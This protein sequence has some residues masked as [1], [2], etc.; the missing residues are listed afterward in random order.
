MDKIDV[1]KR[2]LIYTELK[3]CISCNKCIRECPILKSNVVVKDAGGNYKICVDEKNCILCGT[4][5]YTCVHDVRHYMDDCGDFLQGLKNGK[6][7]SVLVAPSFELNYPK[8]FKRILGYLK[9]LG[10]KNFYPVSLGADIT[11][12]GYLN[13]IKNDSFRGVITQPC[14]VIVRHIEKHLPEL[15][16]NLIPVQSPVICLAT[17]LKKYRGVKEELAFLSPCIAKKDEIKSKRGQNL[18]R[19]NVT[20]ANLL[21]HINNQNINLQDYP[22]AELSGDYGLGALFPFPGGLRESIEFYMGRETEI[23]QIEGEGKAYEFLESLAR[24]VKNPDAS[25]PAFIDILNCKAGCVYGTGT[26]IRN[27]DDNNAIYEAIKARGENRKKVKSNITSTKKHFDEINEIFKELHLEDFL[28]E[29]DHDAALNTREVTD[30]EVEEIFATQLIKFTEDDKRVDCSACGYKTCRQL[31][32]AIVHGINVR[33]VC[34]YYVKNS[35]AQSQEELR[36]ASVENEEHSLMM[37]ARLKAMLDASPMICTIFDEDLK[38]IDIN[39]EAAK[40]LQLSNKQEYIDRFWELSPAIQPDGVTSRE[41]LRALAKHTMETG[42]GHLDEWMH[43]TFKGDRIP[44]EVYTERVRLAE[45]DVI[46]AYGRD[47]RPQNEML[48]KLEAANNAKRTFLANMSHEIRTPMSAIIGIVS[49]AKNTDDPNKKDGYLSKIESASNHLL[50]IINQILDMSKI[51]AEKFELNT[52]PFIFRKMLN[53]I[54]SLINVHTEEKELQLVISLDES[55]PR[56]IVTDELRLAQVITN[57]LSNA[58]KFTPERGRIE[59]R[60]SNAANESNAGRFLLFEITDNGIGI[61]KEKQSTLFDA[62]EQAEAD[63]ARRFGGTGLGLAISR[64]IVEML[65]GSIWLESEPGNGSRFVFMIPYEAGE[66]PDT[67][68]QDTKAI[69]HIRL[70]EHT[71]LLAEDV[72]INREILMSLLEPTEIVVECAEDGEQA[73]EMYSSS[74]ERYG[75]I[76]MDLQ[77]PQ[78]DGFMAASLIREFEAA[79]KISRVPIV[80]ITANVFQEDIDACLAAGMDD[81]VG[82]PLDFSQIIEKLQKYL[83][84]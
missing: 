14:P 16:G 18:I 78:M 36:R 42:S 66:A 68:E 3:G 62:F 73:V 26:A 24:R 21:K 15:L 4:C 57:L 17:F 32:E 27:K 11:T 50:K 22:E 7:I 74:P 54:I 25:L 39:Q 31:A 67:E 33:D 70:K 1:T 47:L 72:E 23:I 45:R 37:Q 56:A 2:G 49:L 63:T 43:I 40:I 58:V 64:H 53:G 12:W 79:H 82:K 30:E 8:E 29:Y 5:T 48:A 71:I 61:P 59:L 65:G 51:E 38:A 75:M 44:V 9:S 19:H 28:C 10:V 20:F 83:K 76:F 80:A 34:V 35:L 77:M 52:H 69:E 84:K 81:H 41:K 55:I 13:Y 6:E 46:L 60:I